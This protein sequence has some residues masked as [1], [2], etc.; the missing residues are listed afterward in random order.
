MVAIGDGDLDG[1]K[2]GDVGVGLGQ[3]GFAFSL[4]DGVVESLWSSFLDSDPEGAD[5]GAGAGSGGGG[6]GDELQKHR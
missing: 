6:V 1:L 5:I 3:L 4:T 2:L